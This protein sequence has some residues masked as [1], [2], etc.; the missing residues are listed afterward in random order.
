MK[1]EKPVENVNVYTDFK[2]ILDPDNVTKLEIKQ[3]ISE[4]RARNLPFPLTK[5]YMSEDEIILAF[6]KLKRYE[7]D[8]Q[9]R[10]HQQLVGHPEVLWLP[11]K[12]RD[13]GSPQLTVISGEWSSIDVIVDYFTESERIK[14][15][16]EYV[17]KCLE[18]LW[19]D[20]KILMQTI[21]HC[22]DNNNGVIDCRHLRDGLFYVS[23]EVTLF[24]TTRAKSFIHMILG[25]DVKGKRWLDMSAGWGDRLMTACALEMEY[26]GYDPNVAL[27][28]G[29]DGMIQRFG[30]ESKQV[31]HYEPFEAAKISG[32][33]KFD[34]SLISPPF[35][36]I[37]RYNGPNQSTETYPL[38]EDWM[39]E[40]LMISLIKIWNHLD[41]ENG[42]L[43]INIAN[44]RGCNIVE[45][46]LLFIEEYLPGSNWE[47]M[48]TYASRGSK[49]CPG[50]I[51]VW[52]KRLSTIMDVDGVIENK[53]VL[54]NP[55]VK[56]SLKLRFP[57]IHRKLTAAL[58]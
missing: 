36:I 39:V 30:D 31:V 1:S 51:Y 52:R 32:F 49:D 24:K 3:I 9:N 50:I 8:W 14:A 11:N 15:R 6:E 53:R 57:K 12:F 55:E 2:I 48:L 10:E 40:F 19:E 38:F 35:Y 18:E 43:A 13:K 26:V 16:K 41:D 56:R 4:I 29:H 47:G 37:E 20:D 17:T 23:K 7:P 5:F 33:E 58:N 54:W 28:T 25:K 44:I 42:Y 22:I 46:M 27:K 45:P 34:V 21:K